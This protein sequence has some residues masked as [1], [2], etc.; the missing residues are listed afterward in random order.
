VRAAAAV[1][2][3]T[4]TAGRP[5]AWHFTGRR[6]IPIQSVALPL[7]DGT[8]VAVAALLMMPG[9]WAVVYLGAVLV[10][11]NAGGEH[12]LRICLRI[13][14]EIPRLV[15]LA[16]L[17]IVVFVPWIHPAVKL[18]VFGLASVILLLTMRAGLYAALRAAHRHSWLTEPA[19]IVGTGQTGAEIVKALIEHPDL[20]LRPVGFIGS[21]PGFI[22]RLP[23]KK[24]TKEPS[25][26]VLGGPSELATVV[27]QQGVSRII[28]CSSDHT[29]G[30]LVTELRAHRQLPVDVC[31]VPQMHELAAAIP[32][33][34]RDDVWGI[35]L[36]PLRPCGPRWSA[37][38]VKRAFDVIVGT[39][40]LLA[41]APLL[42]LLTVVAWLC[43]GRPILFRQVRV[44][45]AGGLMKIAK[46]RTVTTQSPDAQST[47]N[48][49]AQ[50]AV[51]S[52]QCTT[53]G[54]LLRSTHLDELPQLFNVI[55]G[56]MSL[57][58]PRPER[59]HFTSRFAKTIPHYDDRHRVHTGMTGWAQ[60]HGLTGDT[61]I[62]ERV[63]FDNY[64]IEHW[65]LWLDMTI[66]ARTLAEPMTGVLR[67]RGPQP[68]SQPAPR[69]D[70]LANAEGIIGRY[71][72]ADG[73]CGTDDVAARNGASSPAYSSGTEPAGRPLMSELPEQPDPHYPAGHAAQPA[74]D[75]TTDGVEELVRQQPVS[76]E[77][78]LVSPETQF[79]D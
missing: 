42:L 51:S 34:S 44:T 46:F 72:H 41:C 55:R 54:R 7:C 53:L 22:G 77:S 79:A 58:G 74:A 5:K 1:P 33:G 26:P 38:V 9:W 31:V 75:R 19:L 32:A 78:Y 16:A 64:Y 20:G 66:L 17:P 65:S 67:E 18:A 48:P 30:G 68:S 43:S 15:A 28:V 6:A 11:L 76:G 63:R 24:K 21:L 60:V 35:P 27:A 36:I 39:A 25:L 70:R 56:Q 45:R 47:Q 73:F 37:R 10:V 12:R 71:S 49:D 59:P 52:D 50:W 3:R 2:G 57:V 61:S 40:L 69:A 62:S 14:D 8:A 13:S 29:D 23:P 4:S